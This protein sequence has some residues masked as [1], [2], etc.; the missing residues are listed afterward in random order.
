MTNSIGFLFLSVEQY[1]K[2]VI[3][4]MGGIQSRQSYWGCGRKYSK[5]IYNTNGR[6]K[7]YVLAA[8]NDR[9]NGKMHGLS[10]LAIKGRL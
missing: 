1:S 9:Q 5:I 3:L 8:G 2:T 4:C 7:K 10:G 6:S